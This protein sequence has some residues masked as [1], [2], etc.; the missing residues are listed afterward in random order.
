MADTENL[1]ARV[2]AE[3]SVTE[4]EG[5][6]SPTEPSHG[7]PPRV[8]TPETGEYEAV[9][10][11]RFVVA[12]GNERW[13]CGG[14]VYDLIFDGEMVVRGSKAPIYDLCRARRGSAR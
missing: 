7:V 11:S 5:A 14:Y 6:Q 8:R 10:V 4:A 12:V 3:L 1:E 2:C 9:Q 13:N